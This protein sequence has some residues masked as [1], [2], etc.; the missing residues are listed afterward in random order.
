VVIAITPD[1][2]TAFVTNTGSNSVSQIDIGGLRV[3]RTVSLRSSATAVAISPDGATAWVT[4]YSAAS[5]IPISV[6]TGQIGSNGITGLQQ[7][8]GV[9]SSTTP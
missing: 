9:S 4:S 5:L 3:V 2:T 7:P 8:V 6:A 1:S